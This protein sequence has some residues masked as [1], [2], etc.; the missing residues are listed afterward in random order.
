MGGLAMGCSLVDQLSQKTEMWQHFLRLEETG[1]ENGASRGQPGCTL[2]P[3][4]DNFTFPKDLLSESNKF[5]STLAFDYLNP[6]TAIKIQRWNFLRNEKPRLWNDTTVFVLHLGTGTVHTN[7]QCTLHMQHTQQPHQCREE[8]GER[9][10][11]EPMSFVSGNGTII[12]GAI[13]NIHFTKK[14]EPA[15]GRRKWKGQSSV[16]DVFQ[17]E[18]ASCGF[19]G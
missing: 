7:S 17:K 19:T 13:R 3:N 18:G 10:C 14:T 15:G 11:T 8:R 6:L 12:T 4:I 5:C 1:T 2:H 16:T 9:T